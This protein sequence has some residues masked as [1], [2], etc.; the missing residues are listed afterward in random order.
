MHRH[1][2]LI[3]LASVPAAVLAQQW[4]GPGSPGCVG[5]G[6]QYPKPAPLL[7]V[8]VVGPTGANATFMQGCDVRTFDTPIAVGLRP[9]YVYRFRVS[10]FEKYPRLSLWPTVEVIGTLQMPLPLCAK[11]HPAPIVFS[12][13]DIDRALNGAFITKVIYLEHPD[14]AVPVATQPDQ[15][16]ET[17][18]PPGRDLLMEARE[19][20]RPLMI[21]RFGARQYDPQEV[22]CQAIPG[23]MLL[24]GDPALGPP[25]APP[26][27]P[28]Q[29]MLP[30][31]PII[32]PKPPEEECMHDGGDI[33]TRA[34]LDGQGRLLGLD[35][36]D[37]LAEYVDSCGKKR[38]SIS[39][40]VCL[41]VPRFAVLRTDLLPL[42]FNNLVRP[43]NAQVEQVQFLLKRRVPPVVTAQVELPEVIRQRQ[44]PAA[45]IEAVG[46]V[47]IEQMQNTG[48]IIGTQQG[49]MVIGTIPPKSCVPSC[50]LHLCKE[51]DKKCAQIGDV[52]TFTLKYTNPGATPITDVVVSDSLTGRL[53]Y[54]PD[55]QKSDRD[56]LFTTQPNEAGS[57]ILRWQVSG[58]LQPGQT[59]VVSFQ[60]KIR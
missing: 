43:I 57:S 49:Q 18:V 27:L 44:R 29:C 11:N 31:D 23:T 1:I 19:K 8:N 38:L 24:P 59:G 22:G 40:R 17:E 52:V 45:V 2:L 39:N 12:E 7:Y 5:P 46:P 37:T 33:G 28:F 15:P 4:Q 20:G 25:A 9:G 54:V 10:G 13:Q 35:P 32:G 36:S 34:A 26:Y 21:V 42:D 56:A 55:T 3:F 53:E 14:K 50:P 60:V 6:C 58:V 47:I 48:L 30:Y 51:A 41:C 16:L